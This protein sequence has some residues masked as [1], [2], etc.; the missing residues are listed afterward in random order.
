[1]PTEC[2]IRVY[3]ADD[4]PMFLEAMVAAIRERSELELVGW[5]SNGRDAAAGIRET[6]PDVA[7]L[8]MRLRELTGE[9]VL[10]ATAGGGSRILFLSAHVDSDLVYRALAGGAAGYLSKEVDREAICDAVAAV[11]RGEI[12]LSPEVQ[13]KLAGAIRE[14]NA[15]ER[16]VLT[17]RELAILALAA[18]G[19]STREIAMRLNV[20]SATV[21][22]H[23]Q[24]IYAKLDVPDRTSAVAAAMRRGLLE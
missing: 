19:C 8:D 21:K 13:V 11:A 24:S 4:H 12:V 9:E 2:R 15:V 16:P 22:T 17:Q 3:L 18:E 6:Q 23:L 1:V 14:R 7:V 10:R 20:A 5:A